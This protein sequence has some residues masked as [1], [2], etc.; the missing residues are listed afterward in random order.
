M[1]IEGLYVS[2]VARV[3]DNPVFVDKLLNLWFGGVYIA[4]VMVIVAILYMYYSDGLTFKR[5]TIALASGIICIT[6]I[7]VASMSAYNKVETGRHEYRCWVMN[8][9]NIDE[10]KE[11]YDIIYKQ[12]NYIVIRDKKGD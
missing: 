8:G 7:S 11:H 5:F 4:T 6:I 1:N 2:S 10:V 12:K 3:F 9:F